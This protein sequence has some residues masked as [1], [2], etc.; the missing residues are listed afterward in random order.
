MKRPGICV[1]IL[2]AITLACFWPVATFDFT[3]WDDFNTIAENPWLNPPTPRSLKEFWT[4]PQEHLYVPVTYTVWAM[5]ANRA[6]RPLADGTMGLDPRW[7][8]TLNLAIHAAAG[9]MAFLLLRRLVKADVAALIG[10]LFF[11]V[12][13]VQVETVAWTSGTKDLL[14]GMLALLALWQYVD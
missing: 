9:V 13:P 3:S 8:H 1:A 5:L 6:A 14:C 11:V 7:F 12:H 2:L 10:A 4:S